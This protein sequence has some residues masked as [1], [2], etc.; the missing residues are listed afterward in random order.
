MKI[1]SGKFRPEKVRVGLKR[2]PFFG[3][4]FYP[5]LVKTLFLPIREQADALGTGLD[6]VKIVL[7]LS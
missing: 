2:L 1:L 3:P 5:D 7:Q 4:A 6:S